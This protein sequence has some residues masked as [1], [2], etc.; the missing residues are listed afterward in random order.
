MADRS[1]DDHGAVSGLAPVF[2][3]SFPNVHHAFKCENVMRKPGRRIQ[4]MP[5]PRQIS[6]SCG[7]AVEV[8]AEDIVYGRDVASELERGGVDYEGIFLLRQDGRYE[9]IGDCMEEKR[10]Q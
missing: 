4:V 8:Q 6:S 5:V 9:L 7:L 1:V 2:L 10:G 3:I